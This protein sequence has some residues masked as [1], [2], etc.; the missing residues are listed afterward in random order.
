[1]SSAALERSRK[2][3]VGRELVCE[4]LFRPLAHLVV[5]L[6][7]PARV[8]PPLV[9]AASGATG[10][11]AAVELAQGR[12]VLAAILLQLK[13][14]LDNADGQ[15]ARLSGRI[16]AF[17]RYLDSELDLIV[18]AA[19]FGALGWSTGRPVLAAAGFLAL[20]TVLNVN[21]NAERLFRLERG[22]QATAMP[23]TSGRADGLLRRLYVLLYAP[24]DRLVERFVSRRLRDASPQARRAYH[25]RGTVSVLAN[26]GMSTQLLAFG[27]CIAAGRP[28]AFAWIALGE[29]VLVLALALRRELVIRTV[30][31]LKEESL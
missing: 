23:E 20:T 8:A 15:L 12:F 26:L 17:G 7:L 1:M 14:V 18:N 9:A 30:P 25:D 3:K 31:N 10:I 27:V 24:Q 2:A 16:T 29:L 28:A 4:E 22:E 6:L 11:A 19:L 5:L 13:T 21:Y